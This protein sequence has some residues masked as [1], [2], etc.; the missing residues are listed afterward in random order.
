MN[1]STLLQQGAEQVLAYEQTAHSMPEVRHPQSHSSTHSFQWLS[2]NEILKILK[3]QVMDVL[4]SKWVIA[5]TLFF[6]VATEGLL[7]FGGDSSRAIVSLLNIVL[8]LIPL[9]SIIFGTLY[10]YNAREF[11]ELM[12]SQPIK[13]SSLF[14]GMYGGLVLPFASAFAFGS[15]IP[16]LLHAGA[17]GATLITLLLGG[18]VLTF[19]FVALACWVASVFEDKAAGIGAA[20]G[21]WLFF[22]VL[23]DGIVLTVVTAFSDYPL[24]KPVIAMS[25]L[26]PIDLARIL[27]MLKFDIAALMGY[28][29]AV[30]EQFFGTLSGMAISGCALLLWIVLP[31]LDGMRRF[32]RRNF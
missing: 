32:R 22:S 1:N 23:Y 24:E 13:R 12:L 8:I 21:A 4:R 6:F 31:L 28:T 18:V 16:F 27:V 7:R 11:V 19:V 15:G 30:F 25:I 17:N 9:A 10:L 3:Y 14:L 2:M 26:N 20:F 5:Y 29:G